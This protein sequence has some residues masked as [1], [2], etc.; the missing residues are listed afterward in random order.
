MQL[1]REV[2]AELLLRV[3]NR[4]SVTYKA[5]NLS[6]NIKKNMWWKTAFCPEN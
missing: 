6:T 3:D 1:T 2:D 5:G 4:I